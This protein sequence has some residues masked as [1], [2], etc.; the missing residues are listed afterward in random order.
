MGIVSGSIWGQQAQVKISKNVLLGSQTAMQISLA[1]AHN[2]SFVI[3]WY[4]RPADSERLLNM[5]M[6]M[7]EGQCKYTLLYKLNYLT[8]I[9]FAKCIL[10]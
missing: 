6:N 8:D 4:K 9:A 2:W 3:V 10:C 5:N 7:M 1:A